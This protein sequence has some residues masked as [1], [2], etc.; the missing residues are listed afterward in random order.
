MNRKIVLSLLVVASVAA[1]VIADDYEDALNGMYKNSKPIGK[2]RKHPVPVKKTLPEA[3][4]K[5]SADN[6]NIRSYLD[7]IKK[8]SIRN[9][10]QIGSALNNYAADH[11][12]KY[13]FLN[14][15]E[16]LEL[17][18]KEK[19]L[20]EK[21]SDINL[22][23]YI[24]RG[25]LKKSDGIAAIAWDNSDKFE[26]Y[27][28]VLYTD[29]NVKSFT[30]KDWLGKA[31]IAK[32]HQAQHKLE[33]TRSNASSDLLCIGLILMQYALDHNDKF[34]TPDGA[35]GLNLLIKEGYVEDLKIFTSPSTG[36]KPIKPGETLTEKTLDYV[37]RGGLSGKGDIVPIAWS[38]PRNFKNFGVVF[39]TDE[40]IKRFYG[41]DW[42]DQAG[43][44]KIN[45]TKKKSAKDK[46]FS[47]PELRMKLVYVAS[48]SFMM[49]TAETGPVDRV[50]ISKGFWIGK[51]E[52]TQKEYQTLIGTN[53]SHFKGNS[54][55]VEQV[56]WNDAVK[57]CEK[58][59][60]RERAAGRLLEGYVYRLPTEAE[61]EYA[62]RGGNKGK[63]YKYSG[64]NDLD[65]VGWYKDN[66][67]KKTHAVGSKSGNELGI[68]DMSG[69]VWE[70]CNDWFGK[71]D[72]NSRTDPVG[73]STG[74]DRVI[75]GGSW[76]C[77]VRRCRSTYSLWRTPSGQH[78]DLGFRVALA[79]VLSKSRY[80][81]PDVS[82]SSISGQGQMAL[83][84]RYGTAEKYDK[85][86]EKKYLEQSAAADY[87]PAIYLKAYYKMYGFLNYKKE[88]KEKTEKICKESFPG[89]LSLAENGDA[90]AQYIT[91]RAYTTGVGCKEDGV[92]AMLWFQ[93]SYDNGNI[94][95]TY[96]IGLLSSDYEKA[97][98]WYRK[99]ADKGHVSAAFF[100]GAMYY[101]GS[102]VAKNYVKAVEWYE[103]AANKGL[104]HAMY[105]FGYIYYEGGYGI[106]KNN[107]K[108]RFWYQKCYDSTDDEY[109]KK[110]A[111][112]MLNKIKDK[113]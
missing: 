94:L 62:A 98:E 84:Y 3:T 110:S 61:W 112:E 92:K 67:G 53:P 33:T 91:G 43:I 27:G 55:P 46:S 60:E 12:G 77:I 11:D 17:L 64:S 40:H 7:K 103:K 101:S 44:T 52:V 75:S 76:S 97:L 90:T 22:Y 28:N 48:G 42:M 50:T 58:L 107:E 79:P 15:Y 20:K 47:V 96:C 102:G 36:T 70:W 72:N 14:D 63:G 71:L 34:P 19:Y 31:G 82:K 100:I 4:P 85:K 25:G 81:K 83:A 32:I 111:L 105:D 13:P 23:S 24:Y 99:A 95:A 45:K 80:S 56:S 87:P 66:S 74:S 88:K 68:H 106:A 73:P 2:V 10:K 30:G 89:V 6:D 93:K 78:L 18:K 29:G 69:N 65:R 26:D 41:K 108:A 51:Y 38:R 109:W 8:I 9:L 21:A 49:G 5:K 39:Y 35:A 113:K 104:E 16:G 1:G 59:T 57:F 86:L 37:Y 54:N